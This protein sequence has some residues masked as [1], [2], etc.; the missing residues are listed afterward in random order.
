MNR[1]RLLL[2]AFILVAL[3]QLCV[4]YQMI[5]EQAYFANTGNEFRF[6]VMNNHSG[7]FRR[8]NTGTSIQGRYIRLMFEE[9]K[10]KVTD[11]KAVDYT[12]PFYVLFSKDSLGFAKIQLVTNTM[13]EF[14]SDWVK[15]RGWTYPKDSSFLH[16]NYPFNNYYIED[17]IDKNVESKL[18]E[19]LNDSLS[20]ILLKVKIK[21]NK[22]IVSDLMMDGVSFK[23][24]VKRIQNK[25]NN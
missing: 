4:P 1:K 23:D 11:Q 20:V 7:S 6:K 5:S 17:L 21:E 2:I 3:A 22:F 10:F 15:A 24:F 8:G 25:P 19:K 9:D 12:Q 13:P 16:L 14:S 18:S